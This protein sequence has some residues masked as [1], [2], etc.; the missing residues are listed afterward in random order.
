MQLEGTADRSDQRDTIHTTRIHPGQVLGKQLD[1]EQDTH[2]SHKNAVPRTADCVAPAQNGAK[3]EPQTA[4][5]PLDTSTA[6]HLG[7]SAPAHDLQDQ[8]GRNSTLQERHTESVGYQQNP[9]HARMTGHQG[10]VTVV[11][12]VAYW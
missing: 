12:G 9:Q 1:G 3:M 10:Q 11:S 2:A 6:P 8:Q 5:L 4:Q 7:T